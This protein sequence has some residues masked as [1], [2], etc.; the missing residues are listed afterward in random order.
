M[1]L[2]RGWLGNAFCITINN[3]RVGHRL[4]FTSEHPK[5]QRGVFREVWGKRTALPYIFWENA[6]PPQ[7]CLENFLVGKREHSGKEGELIKMFSMF[8][9]FGI[10]GNC[11][12]SDFAPSPSLISEYAHAQRFSL[13][14]L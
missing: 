3:K 11:P 4:G 14:A 7:K 10:N 1:I 6:S 12:K 5:R 2:V 9:L 8:Q 13:V